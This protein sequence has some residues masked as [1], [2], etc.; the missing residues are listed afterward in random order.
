[1]PCQKAVSQWTPEVTTPWPHLSKPQ[2]AVL[3]LGSLG[4]VLAHSCA[5]SAVAAWLAAWLGRK[6]NTVRQPLREFCYEARTQR[7]AQRQALGVEKCFA[8]LLAWVLG[9]WEGNQLALARDATQWGQ[10]FVVLAIRVVYRGCA[11]PVAWAV[12]PAGQKQ[13][14]RPVWLRRL[15]HLRGAIPRSMSVIVLADRGL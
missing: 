14:W 3:A 8:P 11:I 2:A 13:A 10:R 15:R 9:W 7:G 6:E 5:W 4:M 12:R 1:M